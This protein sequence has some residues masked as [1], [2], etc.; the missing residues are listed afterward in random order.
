MSETSRVI[1][2]WLLGRFILAII[3]VLLLWVLV[4]W[5]RRKLN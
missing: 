3:S 2:N 5:V 4:R 1:T